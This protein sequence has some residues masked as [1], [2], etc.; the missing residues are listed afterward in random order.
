MLP[1]SGF[2]SIC[3]KT[4]LIWVIYQKLSSV[5]LIYLSCDLSLKYNIY[6]VKLIFQISDIFQ[7]F[8]TISDNF[9]HVGFCRKMSAFMCHFVSILWL[10][11]FSLISLVIIVARMMTN[12]IRIQGTSNNNNFGICY[13]LTVWYHMLYL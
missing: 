2:A 1:P 6:M 4:S 12:E 7:H 10:Q 13:F 9:R 11:Y 5:R 8:P 3:P